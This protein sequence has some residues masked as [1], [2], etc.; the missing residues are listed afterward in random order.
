MSHQEVI[1]SICEVN[2]VIIMMRRSNVD[3][4]ASVFPLYRARSGRIQYAG[5]VFHGTVDECEEFAG[6]RRVGEVWPEP[7]CQN[8]LFD[9]E[10]RLTWMLE[11][12]P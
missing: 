4:V 1:D 2:R 5:A 7:M 6:D 9:L 12:K 3:V 8:G 10:C 11:E